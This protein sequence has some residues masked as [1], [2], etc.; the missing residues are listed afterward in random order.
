MTRRKARSFYC[1]LADWLFGL[2]QTDFVNDQ[3]QGGN[4][5]PFSDRQ[6]HTEKSARCSR[7]RERDKLPQPSKPAAVWQSR[8]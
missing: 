4:N 7:A 8:V 6:K 5:K 3:N 2:V 1:G